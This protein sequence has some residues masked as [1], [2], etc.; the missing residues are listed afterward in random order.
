M[1]DEEYE[2]YAR[3]INMREQGDAVQ[4]Y[5]ENCYANYRYYPEMLGSL[6][7]PEELAGGVLT[8]RENLG[9]ELLGMTRFM[10]HLDDWPVLHCARYLLETG[11]TEKFLTLLYAHACHHGRPELGCYYEQVDI[12]GQVMAE[13]CIPSLLTVPIMTAWMFAFESTGEKRLSLLSGIPAAWY[14]AGFSARGVGL[15]FGQV[16]IS[17][18]SERIKLRFSEAP[19]APFRLVLRHRRG[20]SPEN[21]AEG[22]AQI[23]AFEGNVLVLSGEEREYTVAFR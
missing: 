6:L 22:G 8:L 21:I 17:A 20:V 4:E 9:G 3:C 2:K 10:G 1:G 15:S 13:D 7:L 12:R 5:T 16:D 14:E 19:G 18:S 11:R 23:L